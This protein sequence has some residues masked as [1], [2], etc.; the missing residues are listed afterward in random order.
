M[1]MQEFNMLLDNIELYFYESGSY[2]DTDYEDY[3]EKQAALI[4]EQCGL[5]LLSLDF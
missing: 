2:Y 1:D 3:I 4:E 5:S